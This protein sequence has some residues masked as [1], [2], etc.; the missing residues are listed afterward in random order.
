MM[1]V[2]QHVIVISL[3]NIFS[4][5]FGGTCWNIFF[6]NSISALNSESALLGVLKTTSVQLFPIFFQLRDGLSH[7]E[8][9][10][11]NVTQ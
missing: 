3:R 2:V 1:W 9:C 10:N 6:F 4:S 7:T 5:C 8:I 11:K